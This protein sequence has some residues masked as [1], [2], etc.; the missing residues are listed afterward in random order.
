MENRILE[1][2]SE[3][4]VSLNGKII[5]GSLSLESNIYGEGYDS[6]KHYTFSKTETEKLFSIITKEDFVK[7]CR[8]E[9]LIGMENFLKENGIRYETFT[10]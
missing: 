2:Y 6:E 1:I 8:K 4:H 7:L 9:R 5:N 3:K 10:I